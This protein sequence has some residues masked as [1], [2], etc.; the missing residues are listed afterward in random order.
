MTDKETLLKDKEK[1][2]AGEISDTEFLARTE[3]YTE[4]P[5]TGT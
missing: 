1:W 2:A 3:A 4:E 5:K